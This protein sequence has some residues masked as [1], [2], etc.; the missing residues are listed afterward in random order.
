F[1]DERPSAEERNTAAF[2]L[3][4]MLRDMR[5]GK[6]SPEG[7]FDHSTLVKR[8]TLA[9]EL[10]QALTPSEPPVDSTATPPATQHPSLTY[11][12]RY[13]LTVLE[14]HRCKS[15]TYAHILTESV[16][17]EREDR[18][19]IRRLSDSTIRTRVRVLLAHQL[20]ARPPGT[21]KK[22]I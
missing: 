15:L 1:D 14:A 11:E 10:V 20:V 3:Q 5:T 8:L 4:D 18:T 2:A 6:Y 9:A 7:K 22:G 19:Q 12:D 17:M 16:R 21:T 13:I